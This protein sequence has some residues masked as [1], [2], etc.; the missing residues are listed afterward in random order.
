MDTKGALYIN[1][2]GNSALAKA[3]SGDVLA[4]II[5]GLLAQKIKTFD[6]AKLG[7]YIHGKAGELASKDLS[8]YSVLASDL[9]NYIG[10]AIKKM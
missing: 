4:G 5:G 8:E 2:T 7:V 9:I 3:G 10:P 6:A 1:K